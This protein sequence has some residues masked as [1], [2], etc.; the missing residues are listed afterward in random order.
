[1]AA[2][3]FT[4]L[5]EAVLSN[6]EQWCLASP[7][8][9]T[10][11]GNVKEPLAREAVELRRFPHPFRAMLAIS[12]DIDGT[13]I[14]VFRETHRF[15]N[16]L[17]KTSM[18]QGIG[19]DVA[20]SFWVYGKG[21]VRE[22][23]LFR[24]SD[25]SER[26][27]VADELLHYLRCGWIDTLHS[28]GSFAAGFTREHAARALELLSGAGI[29][30]RV[31]VNHGGPT[32]TQ[33]LN[34]SGFRSRAEDDRP[35]WQG[36]VST[37]PGYHADLLLDYGLRFAWMYGRE[38]NVF[39]FDRVLAPWQLADHSTIWGFVRNSAEPLSPPAQSFAREN[40]IDIREGRSGER[41]VVLWHPRCLPRQLAREKLDALVAAQQ[42]VIIAQHLGTLHGRRDFS[43][44]TADALR[45]LKRYEDEQRI[46]VAGVGRLLRYEQVR[47]NLE[48]TVSEEHGDTVIDLACVADPIF[49]PFVP[50]LDDVRGIT[51]PTAQPSRVKLLVGGVP[52]PSGEIVRAVAGGAAGPSIGVRWF[53]RDLTDYARAWTG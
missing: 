47:D 40:D 11:K 22:P 20:N 19:L 34:G 14:D 43:P 46:L 18:G 17:G 48:L 9:M 15:L 12:T 38:A 35:T 32:N 29:A 8:P 30:V 21:G 41:W 5:R 25:W 26:S 27:P 13:T 42:S 6:C 39:G 45:R 1:M 52:V 50:A 49:G 28:Y 36:D 3:Y 44:A 4:A 2:Q 7:A 16:T 10:W 31:W 33:N 53:E 24:G 23:T 37:A 51:V